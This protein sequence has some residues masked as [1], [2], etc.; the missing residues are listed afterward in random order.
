MLVLTTA[1]GRGDVISPGQDIFNYFPCII[2][3]IYLY[4]LTVNA[5]GARC[6][7]SGNQGKWKL[8]LFSNYDIVNS[9][10]EWDFDCILRWYDIFSI[11]RIE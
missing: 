5:T 1:L 3:Q 7:L 10:C 2:M 8:W 11:D 9:D 6:Y 4:D